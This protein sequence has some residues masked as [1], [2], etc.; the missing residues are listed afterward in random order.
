MPVQLGAA[1]AHGFDE[2]LGLLS[3]CHRRIENFL[4]ILR[5]VEESADE[6]LHEQQRQAIETALTYFRTAAPRHNEDEEQSLFPLLRNR[7]ERVARSRA[8]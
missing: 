4:S 1:P 6:T 2:P 3:D 8:L 5:K 7:S